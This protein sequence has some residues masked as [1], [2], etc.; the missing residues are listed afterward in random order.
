MRLWLWLQRLRL[1]RLRHRNRFLTWIDFKNWINGNILEHFPFI[2]TKNVTTNLML[3]LVR[4]KIFG[5][6]YSSEEPDLEPKPT[7]PHQH[8][9]SE[10]E[11]HKNDTA[12][13]HCCLVSER[14]REP[15]LR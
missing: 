10:P 13:Q 6:V 2:F 14:G 4:L 8:F 7:E 1:R 3:T 9:S 11:T 5:L 12:P 15:G